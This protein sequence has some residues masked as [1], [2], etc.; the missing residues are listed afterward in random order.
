MVRM[1]TKN[2]F[3]IEKRED[4]QEVF[5]SIT[6]NYDGISEDIKKFGKNKLRPQYADICKVR[7]R[8][9]IETYLFQDDVEK[10]MKR[11]DENFL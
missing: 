4:L 6:K 8:W 7:I 11:K 5:E 1:E 3:Y 10:K 9:K 2:W